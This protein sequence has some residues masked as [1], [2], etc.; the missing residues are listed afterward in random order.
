VDQPRSSWRSPE[1]RRVPPTPFHRTLVSSYGRRPSQP[2]DWDPR[3]K[4]RRDVPPPGRGPD[5]PTSAAVLADED[6]CAGNPDVPDL[7]ATFS[8]ADPCPV[9]PDVPNLPA[10]LAKKDS[11]PGGPDIPGWTTALTT[12]D[13]SAGGEALPREFAPWDSPCE[14][15]C[16][17]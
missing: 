15:F 9:C 1:V 4:L 12:E 11:R 5:I 13:R 3:T 2:L 10:T 16:G 17:V 7:Q 6:P 8:E 14:V